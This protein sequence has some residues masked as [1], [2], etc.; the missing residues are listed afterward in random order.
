MYMIP[1]SII[2]LKLI[3]LSFKIHQSCISFS[4]DLSWYDLSHVFSFYF[5]LLQFQLKS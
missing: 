5:S 1:S 2:Y 4:L 3:I